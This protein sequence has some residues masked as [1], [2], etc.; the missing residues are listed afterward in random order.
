MPAHLHVDPERP[1]PLPEPRLGLPDRRG[2]VAR[3]PF[4]E[5]RVDRRLG[6][7]GERE[8]EAVDLDHLGALDPLTPPALG[9]RPSPRDP[10]SYIH[11]IILAAR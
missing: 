5:R 11:R 6:D 3:L 10:L 2:D 1:P 7:V 4:D 9:G 8:H